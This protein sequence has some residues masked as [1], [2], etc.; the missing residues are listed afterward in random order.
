MMRLLKKKESI[1]SAPL[2]NSSNE[3]KDSSLVKASDPLTQDIKSPK[4]QKKV[5]NQFNVGVTNYLGR[6]YG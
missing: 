4:K 5:I 1:N 2:N 3:K 6:N